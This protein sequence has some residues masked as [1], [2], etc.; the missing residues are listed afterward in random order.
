MDGPMRRFRIAREQR[1]I[2][3]SNKSTK[4]GVS[5]IAMLHACEPEAPVNRCVHCVQPEETRQIGCNTHHSQ[6]KSD[7]RLRSIQTGDKALARPL[8]STSI[9]KLC[10]CDFSSQRAVSAK[11]PTTNHMLSQT[12]QSTTGLAAPLTD[13]SR[14]AKPSS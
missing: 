3:M 10:C 2:S 6:S 8:N 5:R 12:R 4:Q 11:Q 14:V 9:L 1:I 7:S 13:A